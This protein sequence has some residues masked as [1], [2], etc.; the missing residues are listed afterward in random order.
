M[1]KIPTHLKSM[2]KANPH[3]HH[4]MAPR[5]HSGKRASEGA[6]EEVGGIEKGRV[7]KWIPKRDTLFKPNV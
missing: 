4:V 7:K 3:A 6:S 2:V 1:D 5:K